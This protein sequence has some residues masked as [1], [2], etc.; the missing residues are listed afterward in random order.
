MHVIVEQY[1][2]RNDLF[3][4]SEDGSVKENCGPAPTTTTS[5]CDHNNNSTATL[6]PPPPSHHFTSISESFQH[7]SLFSS[8]ADLT[9]RKS[10]SIFS[11]VEELA[12]G[13]SP[14]PPAP[15]LTISSP[16]LI[17]DHMTALYFI[18]DHVTSSGL[19]YDHLTSPGLVS[20][21]V[22]S[23]G[24]IS[25][26]VTSTPITQRSPLMFDMSTD[27]GYNDSAL[28]DVT[29]DRDRIP[30]VVISKTADDVMATPMKMAAIRPIAI[31]PVAT[32]AS[33]LRHQVISVSAIDPVASDASKTGLRE[34]LQLASDSSALLSASLETASPAQLQ[35]QPQENIQQTNMGYDA[36]NIQL[37]HRKSPPLTDGRICAESKQLEL[38]HRG[39]GVR[40]PLLT[41]IT[42]PS[43]GTTTNS[44]L[45]SK[46]IG[47]WDFYSS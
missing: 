13:C 8:D 3:V 26:H 43:N 27:S 31:K 18:S 35:Q 21:H 37:I 12:R 16:S 40:N 46:N 14:T 22:T 41:R 23:G 9:K 10:P 7:P 34:K 36:R 28:R 47:T 15:T 2:S 38:I 1:A 30:E 44:Q 4:C 24:L 17:S 11:S 42:D 32:T 29:S 45:N 19:I 25:N 20:D 5:D 33:V 6:S 39:F